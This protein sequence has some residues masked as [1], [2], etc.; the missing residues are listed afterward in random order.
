MITSSESRAALPA[1][2]GDKVRMAIYRKP[3]PNG[4]AAFVSMTVTMDGQFY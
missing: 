2:I 3:N 4:G 1:H